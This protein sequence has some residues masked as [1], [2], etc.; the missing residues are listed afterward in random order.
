MALLD[1][2]ME[3]LRN[4]P[5]NVQRTAARAIL[6]YAT[7]YED[8]QARA[9]ALPRPAGN[10][11]RQAA[12]AAANV[13]RGKTLSEH[14]RRSG[15]GVVCYCFGAVAGGEVVGDVTGASDRFVIGSLVRAF[16]SDR[17]NM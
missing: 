4:L 11:G 13:G 16:Q 9:L 3:V 15:D 10:P 1:E 17:K 8:D 7:A 12:S 6:D 5:E 14:P 2:A